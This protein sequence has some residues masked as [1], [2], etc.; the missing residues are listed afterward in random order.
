MSFGERIDWCLTVARITSHGQQWE[1]KEIINGY[2]PRLVNGRDRRERVR[3]CVYTWWTCYLG[4]SLIPA[5]IFLI[6]LVRCISVIVIVYKLI[7]L[8]LIDDI[9]RKLVRRWM[10][11]LQPRDWITLKK[12]L[13]CIVNAKL[14]W[15]EDNYRLLRLRNKFAQRLMDDYSRYGQKFPRVRALVITL[16]LR[17]FAFD[18]TRP[19]NVITIERSSD[20]VFCRRRKSAIGA[21]LTL[22]LIKVP[23]ALPV[24]RFISRVSAARKNKKKK[25]ETEN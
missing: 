25:R 6:S 19:R 1:S 7:G 21:R 9:E 16:S 15:E 8:S 20:F 4:K 13:G 23:A 2:R 18:I 17:P 10:R 3:A 12:R 24:A 14:R 22:R 11:P 5:L